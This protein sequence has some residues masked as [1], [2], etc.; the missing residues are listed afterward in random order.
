MQRA[1]LCEKG[2][3]NDSTCIITHYRLEQT[4]TFE[5][6]C[7]AVML[8]EELVTWSYLCEKVRLS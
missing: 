1:Q 4:K 8:I 5:Y 7:V 6:P 2:V 3:Y